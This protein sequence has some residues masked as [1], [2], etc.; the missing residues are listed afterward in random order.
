MRRVTWILLIVGCHRPNYVDLEG[1]DLSPA[2][3]PISLERPDLAPRSLDDAAP[4]SGADLAAGADLASPAASP[5]LSSASSG[6]VP[7]GESCAATAGAGN[8]VAGATCLAHHDLANGGVCYQS[9][10]TDSD[11]PKAFAGNVG[12]VSHCLQSPANPAVKTCTIPCNPVLQAGPS[13]CAAGLF[14]DYRIVAG[15]EVTS[16]SDDPGMSSSFLGCD[17]NMECSPGQFCTDNA[18]IGLHCVVLCRVGHDED[19][20]SSA[21]FCGPQGSADMFSSCVKS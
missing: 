8:C 3:D 9:C 20:S 6:N 12:N 15:M 19:C 11:C 13:G 1:L 10:V 2:A 5:D 14:C 16:C 17:A 4:P 18:L 21:P 7:V